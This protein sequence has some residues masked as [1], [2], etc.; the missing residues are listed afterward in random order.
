MVSFESTLE[1][2]YAYV[3]DFDPEVTC[4]TE[5]PL[6][7]EYTCAGRTLHYTPDFEVAQSGQ[8]HWLVECKP[9][10]LIRTEDNQRK[11]TAAQTWCAERGWQFEVVTDAQ[12][13]TGCRLQNIK[14]LTYHARFTFSLQSKAQVYAALA[15]ALGRMTVGDVT[16]A[17]A[18]QDPA[19]ALALIWHMAFHHE[20]LVPLDAAPLSVH[21]PITLPALTRAILSA[22]H[23]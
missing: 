11:F 17:V 9:Q 13:R 14:F 21:S 6:T 2:D 7:I 3:L 19:T 4:F 8:R 12:L 10:H 20:V 1:R 15:S 5:Q 22:D 23:S 18:V 16:R